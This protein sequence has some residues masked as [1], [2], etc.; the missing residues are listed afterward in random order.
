MNRRQLLKAGLFAALAPVLA[1]VVKLIPASL[2][3]RVTITEID[4]SSRIPHFPGI[5]GGIWLPPMDGIDLAA[6]VDD[7]GKVQL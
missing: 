4:M 5:S 2:R 1:P 3:P 7:D 6:S